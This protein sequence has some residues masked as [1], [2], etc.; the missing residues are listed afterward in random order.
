MCMCILPA[1]MS[2]NYVV[3][4]CSLHICAWCPQRP[5]E[6]IAPLELE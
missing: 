5:K 1:Y 4:V 2:L 6:A 3:N